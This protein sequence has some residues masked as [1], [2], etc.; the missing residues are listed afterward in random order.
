VPDLPF[1]IDGD[2]MCGYHTEVEDGDDPCRR[3]VV[4]QA[5]D[6]LQL[7]FEC[8][9]SYEQ[10]WPAGSPLDPDDSNRKTFN[11]DITNG[12]EWTQ[13]MRDMSETSWPYCGTNNNI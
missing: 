11:C 13:D 5:G 7:Q 1:V 8:P 6:T 12:P 2:L 9:P 4:P 3:L 10:K